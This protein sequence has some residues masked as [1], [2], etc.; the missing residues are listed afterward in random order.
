MSRPAEYPVLPP[1][2]ILR[3]SSTILFA[4]GFPPTEI[5]ALWSKRTLETTSWRLHCIRV[6]KKQ[7]MASYTHPRWLLCSR[8]SLRIVGLEFSSSMEPE[9]SMMKITWL[10]TTLECSQENRWP[11]SMTYPQ[12]KITSILVIKQNYQQSFKCKLEV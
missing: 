10:A 2:L 9:Q 12:C 4:I 5:D 8:W 7:R 11:S 6:S 3:S 1:G